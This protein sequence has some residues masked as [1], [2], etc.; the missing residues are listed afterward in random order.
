MVFC[1][2]KSESISTNLWRTQIGA[3]C[4]MTAKLGVMNTCSSI[5]NA[6]FQNS[7]VL[8]FFFLITF[9]SLILILFS[10]VQLN[11]SPKKDSSKHNF[12]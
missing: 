6:K 4:I 8:S 9:L 5:T 7:F 2:Y 11:P 1:R 12:Y 3:F 10:N